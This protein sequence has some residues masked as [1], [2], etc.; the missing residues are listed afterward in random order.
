MLNAFAKQKHL[1]HI[2]PRLYHL[3]QFSKFWLQQQLFTKKDFCMKKTLCNIFK[4][5][6]AATMTKTVFARSN[7]VSVRKGSLKFQVSS[8]T[9]IIQKWQYFSKM[10]FIWSSFFQL[11]KCQVNFNFNARIICTRQQISWKIWLH[12]HLVYSPSKVLNWNV[13]YF[14]D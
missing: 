14:W 5:I 1:G 9:E 2:S 13:T 12:K 6:N 4:T 10:H 11:H 3:G 7:I 8:C